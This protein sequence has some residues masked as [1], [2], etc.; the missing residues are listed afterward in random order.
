MKRTL[1]DPL[2][3]PGSLFHRPLLLKK[4]VRFHFVVQAILER[5][6][7]LGRHK[8]VSPLSVRN[9]SHPFD[10][11]LSLLRPLFTN[12]HFVRPRKS[13]LLSFNLDANPIVNEHLEPVD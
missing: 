9:M 2:D 11:V 6:I 8:K 4:R 13:N 1:A 7:N 3:D 12:S 5:L 10:K